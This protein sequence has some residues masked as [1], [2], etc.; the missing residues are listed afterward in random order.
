MHNDV[1]KLAGAA[2]R[3][4]AVYSRAGARSLARRYAAGTG[5]RAEMIRDSSRREAPRI[6]SDLTRRSRDT[7][8]SPASIFAM[9]DWLDWRR[10]ARPACVRLRRRRRSRRPVASR[11]LRS[12]YAASSALRPRNC[13]GVPIFQPLASSR[14]RFPSRTLVL[15]Q[16]PDARVNDDLWRRPRLLAEDLQNHHGVG[17]EPVHDS[18]VSSGVTDPEL[19]TA[20]PHNGHRPRLRHADRL[21]LLQQTKQITGLDPGRLG[22]WHTSGLSL[23]LTAV[24]LC[25]IRHAVKPWLAVH[26][27]TLACSRR[28]TAAADTRRWAVHIE[29]VRCT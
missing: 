14:L 24:T 9:R 1:L 12:I 26:R 23:G 21:P 17:V 13:C 11:T 19:M 18:P 29:D 25:Q 5:D 28:P 8:G 20:R 2:P 4:L 27:I 16:S 22:E 10:F 3:P 7:E 15:P 6:S